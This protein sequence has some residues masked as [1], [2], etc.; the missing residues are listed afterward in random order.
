MTLIEMR[1]KAKQLASKGCTAGEIVLAIDCHP[2]TAYQ[3]ITDH[4][5][6]WRLRKASSQAVK[7]TGET[8]RGGGVPGQGRE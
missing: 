4:V 7:A 2:I 3:A 5:K 1:D 6:E 8:A